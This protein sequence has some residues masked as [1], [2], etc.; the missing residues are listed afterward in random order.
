MPYMQRV[1]GQYG[2]TED[3]A[4]EYCSVRVPA[5]REAGGVV[6]NTR[7]A[8]PLDVPFLLKHEAAL[9]DGIRKA[10]GD[11]AANELFDLTWKSLSENENMQQ[12]LKDYQIR[13]AE[14]DAEGNAV[15]DED[16]N[17]VY[18][19]LTREEQR[20][21]AEE[22]LAKL[23]ETNGVPLPEI[24]QDH[25]AE[26]DAWGRQNGFDT[27]DLTRKEDLVKGWMAET[28][29][30]PERPSWLTRLISSIRIWLNRHGWFVHHLSDDDILTILAKS[31][32]AVSAKRKGS[33]VESPKSKVE[34]ENG[35][36]SDVRYSAAA[37]RRPGAP[38]T[39]GNT[40]QLRDGN[41][42]YAAGFLEQIGF[43]DYRVYADYEF[44]RGKHPNYFKTPE[45]A[46]AS[47]EFVLDA[48]VPAGIVNGNPAFVRQDAETGEA[49]RIELRGIEKTRQVHVRSV[50]KLTDAQYKNAVSRSDTSEDARPD[51]STVEN[52][53]RTKVDFA[54]RRKNGNTVSHFL[55]YDSTENQNVNGDSEN[56]TRFSIS[57]VWTGSAADYD[58]PS[59]QYIGTG[60]GA[61]VYGWGL[62]GSDQRGIGESYANKDVREKREK[63][64]FLNPFIKYKGRKMR[65]NDVPDKAKLIVRNMI[66]NGKDDYMDFLDRNIR[67]EK[68]FISKTEAELATP[69]PEKAKKIPGYMA[70]LRDDIQYS[71]ERIEKFEAKAAI[72]QDIEIPEENINRPHRNLYRQT[73]WPDKEENLLLWNEAVPPEQIQQIADQAVKEGMSNIAYTENGKNFYSG[74]SVSGEFLYKE[75]CKP[76]ALGSPK[77]ASEFLYRAGIDGVKYPAASHGTGDGSRGWNYVAFSDKD[78]RVDEHI[79]YS[80]GEVDGRT[81]NLITMMQPI[82]G[83]VL[84]YE[85]AWYAKQM[86]DKYNV[87]LDETEARVIAIEAIRQNQAD[88]RIYSLIVKIFIS[89]AKKS[90]ALCIPPPARLPGFNARR[91]WTISR[92]VW[93][94]YSRNMRKS[95][96][97]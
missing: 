3:Q 28:G 55:R 50:H 52:G 4:F 10:F 71:R 21:A 1:M 76:F 35:N 63:L 26:I 39:A 84:E 88:A 47:V 43:S 59:L 61:Q 87:H 94:N 82:A 53:N 74:G 23:G 14:L 62:Y 15:L 56:N 40:N 42:P 54:D 65:A 85:G 6:I 16:G 18:R 48:P 27:K 70:G 95:S 45:E 91:T 31:A 89:G 22:L 67:Q 24:Y 32:G 25:R 58:A 66:M 37:Y 41:V 36:G 12:I 83:M 5:L 77:A 19:E 20:E 96:R 90:R 51:R 80:I 9:H 97:Y 44:L 93:I 57:P 60:E 8:R 29:F 73:F 75:L 72:A 92:K 78:I 46:R 17:P 38:N 2:L 11:K 33:K 81:K 30:Q 13:Q 34:S 7:V 86:R 68:E 79:R 49:W 69:D 64:K